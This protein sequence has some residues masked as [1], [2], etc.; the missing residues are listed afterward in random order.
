MESSTPPN[1]GRKPVAAGPPHIIRST[2][3]PP[4][5]L[6]SVPK[7][8]FEATVRENVTVGPHDDKV[9]RHIFAAYVA[10]VMYRKR[11]R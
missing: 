8:V 5:I 2:V 11:Q 1:L 10:D 9:K 6:S 3:T 4:D 7:Y